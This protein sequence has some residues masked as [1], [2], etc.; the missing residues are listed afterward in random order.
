MKAIIIAGGLG[1][2]LR[3]LTYNMPKPV[4]PLANKPFIMHQI[5]L[6]KKF[7]VSEVIL[8]LHYLPESIRNIIDEEAILGVKVDYSLE[9]HPLGTAGAVKNAEQFFDKD[10][11]IVLNGDIFTDI[12]IEKMMKFHRAKKAKVTLA[13]TRVE[14]PTS[15]GLVILDGDGRVL[16][17]REKP[18]W[19]H[20]TANT[21]NAGIYIIEPDVFKLVPKGKEFSFERQLYPMLLEK[22]EKMYGFVTDAY[23]MDIGS[24]AKYLAAHR[25]ILSGD[26]LAGVPGKKISGNIWVEDNAVIS[27][28]AKVKGPALIGSECSL[29]DE[30]VLEEFV[31]LGYG[32]KVGKGSRLKNCVIHR[33]TVINEGVKIENS[34]LGAGCV[35]EDFSAISGAVLADGSIL[36]K[37]SRIGGGA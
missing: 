10:P 36:K 22:G 11:L 33:E 28:S 3:P 13:L 4:V 26:V 15:Y 29:A 6:L 30:A 20:V 2:R 35:I 21:I 24:P 17:F 25:D 34:I 9:E 19:E 12:N 27:A 5:E 18:S 7:G 32:V 1:T 37:G 8:N 14:D 31:V 16:E 23:W